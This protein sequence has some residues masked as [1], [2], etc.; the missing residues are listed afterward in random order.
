MKKMGPAE[1]INPVEIKVGVSSCLLGNKV[2][3]DGRDKPN[4]Y[5]IETLGRFLVFVPICPELEA[6]LGVP[7]EAVRLAGDPDDLRLIGMQSGRDLTGR[8]TSYAARRLAMKDIDNLSGFILKANSP[9]CGL[10]RM[11]VY[12]DG[13]VVRNDGVGLFA[14]AL[15]K[16]CPLLPVEDERGLLD[17]DRGDNFI[18][19]VYAYYRLRSTFGRRYRRGEAVAFHA[20]AKYQ[21]LAHSPEHYRRMGRLVATVKTMTPSRFA[22]QYG[23]L[24]MDALRMRATRGKHANV[25]LHILGFLKKK[26]DADDRRRLVEAI[27]QFR[28]G[29]TPLAAP[30]ALLKFHIEKHGIAGLAGQYYLDPYSGESRLR[31]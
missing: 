22:E 14:A 31:D 27:D 6:G 9:S 19:R 4:H 29:L 12:A 3:Y 10:R 8:V 11:K 17:A 30:L 26:I 18:E 21:I 24:F 16:A 5:I 28:R 15:M 2:R 7:R 13:R 20:A 1:A 25:L 23:L